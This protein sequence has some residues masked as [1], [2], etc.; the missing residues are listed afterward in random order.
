MEDVV[1]EPLIPGPAHEMEIGVLVEVILTATVVFV[2]VLELVTVPNVPVGVPALG[3]TCTVEDAVHPDVGFMAVKV[4]IPE[5]PTVVV[6]VLAPLLQFKFDPPVALPD[7][8]TVGA[9]QVM[10]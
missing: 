9:A 1:V 2:Q 7:S 3:A 6:L 5:L 8:V 10:V 4:K